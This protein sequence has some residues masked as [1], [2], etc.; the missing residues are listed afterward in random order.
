M[1][2]YYRIY[3]MIS[4][5]N[6]NNINLELRVITDKDRASIERDAFTYL[7][8]YLPIERRNITGLIYINVEELSDIGN[9]R[10]KLYKMYNKICNGVLLNDKDLIILVNNPDN[11]ILPI[12]YY[13][14]LDKLK[15]FDKHINSVLGGNIYENRIRITH[16]ER[17][18]I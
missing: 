18:H 2:T 7:Y 13:D 1:L 17:L 8:E 14:K 5:L 15:I 9:I 12:D 3:G 10:C 16:I 11:I 4:Y 6:K